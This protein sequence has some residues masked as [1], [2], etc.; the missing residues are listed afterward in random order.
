MPY[1]DKEKKLQY[2]RKYDKERRK[3]DPEYKRKKD[4][5]TKRRRLKKEQADPE[6][7]EKIKIAHRKW[8][9][10]KCEANPVYKEKRYAA[11]RKWQ[12]EKYKN[13]PE[14]KKRRMVEAEGYWERYL[15][16]VKDILDKFY[17]N[18]CKNCEEADRDCL[19]AHHENPKNKKF[20]LG[21]LKTIRPTREVL[22]KELAKCS[23]LCSNCHMKLHARQR[24]R[25]K[26]ETNSGKKL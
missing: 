21:V 16:E 10:E 23:C 9:Q 18:G 13:D 6:Y 2:Q 15:A 17:E 11:S 14:Y 3:T 25:D 7:K 20:R 12:R 8:Y 24:R 19:C 4:D 5:A 26:K 1:K 22:K